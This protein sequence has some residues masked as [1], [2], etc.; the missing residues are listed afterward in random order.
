MPG[1]WIAVH[2]NFMTCALWLSEI[3]VYAKVNFNSS[4]KSAASILSEDYI[5][6]LNFFFVPSITA[7][8]NSNH[9]P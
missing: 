3:E 5:L 6:D 7:T 9:S 1:L 4:T 2:D 8:I